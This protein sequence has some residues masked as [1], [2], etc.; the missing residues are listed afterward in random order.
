MRTMHAALAG[1]ARRFGM[2]RILPDAAGFAEIVV[3]DALPVFLRVVDEFELEVSARL[4]EFDGRLTGDV[5]AELLRW[6]GRFDGLRFAVEP[7][8]GGVVIGRRVDIRDFSDAR[9]CDLVAEFVLVVADWRRSGAV[10]L[11]EGVIRH[12][13]A[14]ETAQ[15]T[16]LRL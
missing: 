8:R 15:M 10:Q 12:H 16:V 4:P 3:A 5:L 1:V 6:N 13:E 9:L 14:D 7:E 11:L 2:E